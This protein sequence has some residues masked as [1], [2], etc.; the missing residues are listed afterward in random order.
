MELRQRDLGEGEEVV[1][2]MMMVMVVFG[3]VNLERN[4]ERE[5]RGL[6]S[7]HSFVSE[8]PSWP[9]SHLG[10]DGM[11]PRTLHASHGA[12]ASDAS[13]QSHLHAT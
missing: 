6:A 3:G 13:S 7:R 5:G 2:V 4:R 10:G 11:L 8:T 9:S 12:E 1:V